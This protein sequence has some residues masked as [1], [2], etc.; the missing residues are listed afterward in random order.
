VQISVARI[1]KCD[2]VLFR[3]IPQLAPRS[4]VVNLEI[5]QRT[6]SLAAPTVTL[7]DFLAERC[8]KF[9]I[10]PQPRLSL[11]R[12]NGIDSPFAFREL[13]G[14]PLTPLA[15]RDNR[16][17]MW[18]RS[19]PLLAIVFS[20]SQESSLLRDITSKCTRTHGILSL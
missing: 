1:T 20:A 9:R 16:Q 6:A 18:R 10:E 2:Q 4:N 17:L 13:H 5:L 12:R 8:V 11:P 7:Q 14:F 19:I 3:V 15:I